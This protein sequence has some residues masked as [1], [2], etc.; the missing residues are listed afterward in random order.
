MVMVAGW[1]PWEVKRLTVRERR[2][3]TAWYRAI[4]ER[5]VMSE[6]TRAA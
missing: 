2:F 3:W 1:K 6:V 5:R 4:E